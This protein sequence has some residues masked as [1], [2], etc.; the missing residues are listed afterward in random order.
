MIMKK[1]AKTG[2]IIGAASLILGLAGLFWYLGMTSNNRLIAK[3]P[4]DSTM[5]FKADLKSLAEKA[6]MERI[7]DVR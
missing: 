5:V 6:E 2:L 3:I 1:S 7:V 4:K